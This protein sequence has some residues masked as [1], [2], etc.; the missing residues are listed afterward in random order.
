MLTILDAGGKSSNTRVLGQSPQ[1]HVPKVT[2]N[3]QPSWAGDTE[4]LLAG[5][6][7]EW[8]SG[9]G[10]VGEEAGEGPVSGPSQPQPDPALSVTCTMNTWCPGKRSGKEKHLNEI[11]L[12]VEGA[13]EGI[14]WLCLL[15]SSGALEPQFPFLYM[16][17]DPEAWPAGPA[18]S[19]S[20]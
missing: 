12:N 16:C 20:G 10:Q 6:A 17:G 2:G 3:C 5:L 19:S 4:V 8:G 14:T 15:A 13:G 7:W 9:T 11:A 18:V 1:K